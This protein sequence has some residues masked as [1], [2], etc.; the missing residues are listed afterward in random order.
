MGKGDAFPFTKS[1]QILLEHVAGVAF[2][3]G[4]FRTQPVQELLVPGNAGTPQIQRCKRSLMEKVVAVKLQI[5]KPP[6]RK[7]YLTFG[8]EL[9]TIALGV[10]DTQ[11][12]REASGM[13]E[14]A[15]GGQVC[16]GRRGGHSG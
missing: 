12:E 6:A 5:E 7:A 4:V 10:S 15:Q 3:L 14:A 11:M 2:Q 13:G 9:G 16:A 1:A 8:T